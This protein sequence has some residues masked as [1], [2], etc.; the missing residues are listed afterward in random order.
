[1]KSTFTHTVYASTRQQLKAELLRQ[2]YRQVTRHL[3]ISGRCYQLEETRQKAK[4]KSHPDSS[5]ETEGRLVRF[6]T[7]RPRLYNESKTE[8]N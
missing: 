7:H 2:Y 4:T 3:P 5:V 1:M 8:Q 6:A